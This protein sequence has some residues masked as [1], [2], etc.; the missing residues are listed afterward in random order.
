MPVCRQ[1]RH[2]Q[3]PVPST[4]TEPSAGLRGCL[5]PI[6]PLPSSHS[7][8]SHLGMYSTSSYR[9]NRAPRALAVG[10]DPPAVHVLL[11]RH[12]P[13]S[14]ASACTPGRRVDW[15]AGVT[16][17]STTGLAKPPPFSMT[18]GRRRRAAPQPGRHDQAGDPPPPDAHTVR[19]FLPPVRSMRVRSVQVVREFTVPDPRSGRCRPGGAAGPFR[20]CPAYLLAALSL[21]SPRVTI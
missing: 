4:T 13:V 2:A 14:S 7:A 3:R 17:S 8:R 19:A 11:R 1:L 9:P 5:G 18:A 10:Q 21:S 16:V 6:S 12:V 20:P 15:R